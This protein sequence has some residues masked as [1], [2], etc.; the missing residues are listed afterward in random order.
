MKKKPKRRPWLPTYSAAVV[1]ELFPTELAHRAECIRCA[2]QPE[3]LYGTAE[4]IIDVGVDKG[5]DITAQWADRIVSA[6]GDA[7][8]PIEI[9][10]RMQRAAA[11]NDVRPFAK[12]ASQRILHG[13]M[14][15]VL[16]SNWEGETGGIVAPSKFTDIPP[17]PSFARKPFEEAVSFF[18]SKKVLSPEA[19][20]KLDA[21]ARTRAFSIARAANEE[22]VSAAYAE[23]SRRIAEGADLA[24]F[25]EFAKT[26]LES[27]GWVPAN[28]SHI[29]LI[30][31]NQVI[32]AYSRGRHAEMTQPAVL[33]ARPIWQIRG[34][35]DA[36]QRDNHR[37]VNGVAVRADDPVWRTKFP[38]YGNNCRCRA[39]SR[40]EA[41]VKRLDIP[42]VGGAALDPVPD[43]GWHTA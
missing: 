22:L 42:I 14:L 43:P 30:F 33:K 28:K 26:R 1:A 19:F 13:A 27:A 18:R 12:I 20:K 32:G 37:A 25:K 11:A 16:D 7:S 5:V 17:V 10:T 9:R 21:A 38:P 41:D 40:S 39:V 31:R 36:R 34:V 15:G 23:L 24:S 8:T 29:E 4:T 3:T 2:R 6:I 35:A